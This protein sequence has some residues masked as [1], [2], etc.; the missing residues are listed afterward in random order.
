M[1]TYFH[2][3]QWK[4][5]FPKKLF[6]G[7]HGSTNHL[8]QTFVLHA[9]LKWFKQSKFKNPKGCIKPKEKWWVFSK[10]SG[11]LKNK[12]V[13]GW[14]GFHHFLLTM[15]F[16]WPRNLNCHYR[17]RR[18]LLNIMEIS[19]FIKFLLVLFF[20]FDDATTFFKEGVVRKRIIFFVTWISGVTLLIFVVII[21]VAKYLSCCCCCY[22]YFGNKLK[23]KYVGKMSTTKMSY[24]WVCS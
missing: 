9:C 17:K 15:I 2:D 6:R 3:Q 23:K 21:V 5:V 7:I 11:G 12:C 1:V 4:Q 13:G 20:F 24:L 10:W 18:K 16:W 19:F 8:K 14:V 22:D